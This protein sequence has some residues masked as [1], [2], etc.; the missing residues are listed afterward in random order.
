MSPTFY[1]FLHVSSVILLVAGTFYAFAAPESSRKRLLMLT[2]IASVLALVGAFGLLAKTYNMVFYT[3]VVVKLFCW[4]L[5]SGLTGVA[6]RR[7]AQAP[8]WIALASATVV[9][10]VAMVYFKPGM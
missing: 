2:G 3:W 10:A 8:L 7:R 9:L 6:F 4:L 5:L 1:S